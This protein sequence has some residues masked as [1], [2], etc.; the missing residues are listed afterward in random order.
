M[1]RPPPAIGPLAP[2]EDGDAAIRV[3]TGTPGYPVDV[4]AIADGIQIERN[5]AGSVVAVMF[6]RGIEGV[7]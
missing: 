4:E 1:R 5:G 7:G 3:V 6:P 2:Y